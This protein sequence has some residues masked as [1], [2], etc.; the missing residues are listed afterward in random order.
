MCTK[1]WLEGLKGRHLSED[2]GVHWEDNIKMNI[3]EVGLGCVDWI[4]WLR[5][6]A[7]CVGL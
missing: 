4:F 6:R 7:I 3:R 5:I 1:F 2:L